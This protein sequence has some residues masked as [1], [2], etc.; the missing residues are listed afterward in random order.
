MISDI[1]S[2]NIQNMSQNIQL[3]EQNIQNPEQNIQ[4]P[5]QNIQ[6]SEQNF[7]NDIVTCSDNIKCEK[8]SKMLSSKKVLSRHMKICKGVSNTLECHKC[9]K[10]FS[11]P[12]TKSY[13]LKKCTGAVTD[14]VTIQSPQTIIN[15]S[16]TAETINNNT[17]NNNTINN[18]T[19]NT[20]NNI[21]IYNDENIEFKDDHITRKDLKRIFH[22][23]IKT[24]QAISEYAQKLFENTENL[25]IRKKHITNSYC[26]VHNGDGSWKTRP[27]KAVFER[28]SQD[29][30]ISANDKLY[31][32]PNIGT[33]KVRDEITELVSD[34]DDVHSQAIQLRREMRSLIIDK[35]KDHPE[36]QLSE[37]TGV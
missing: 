36:Q 29:V 25:C 11:T 23:H 34:P 21:I 35:T 10:I 15:N 13:H 19:N 8:C 9:H 22:D 28:F 33:K 6:N 7:K 18:I 32:H 17:T 27:E 5:E 24:I 4:N 37:N 20:I 14:L 16:Q 3:W 1:V 26:E 2:Q 12:Q 31:D 30:A